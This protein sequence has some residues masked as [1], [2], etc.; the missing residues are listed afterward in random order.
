MLLHFGLVLQKLLDP[1][2]IGYVAALVNTRAGFHALLPGFQGREFI[3]F[4]TGPPCSGNPAIVSNVGNGAL[5]AHQVRVLCLRQMLVENAIK[6]PR[7]VLVA[8]DSV[9]KNVG[10]IARE[11]VC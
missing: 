7:L 1:V 8:R 11:V 9:L 3:H 2:R 10:S 4:N 5:V 6:A